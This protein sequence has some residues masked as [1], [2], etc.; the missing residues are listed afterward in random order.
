MFFIENFDF[1]AIGDITTDAFIRLKDASVHCQVN[2]ESCEICLKFADKVPFEFSEVVKAV[3]NAANAAVAASRLDLNTAI[4]TNVGDDENGRDCYKVLKSNGVSTK[5][6]KTQAGKPTNYHYVL[7]YEAERTILVN[8]VNYDYSLPA[9]AKRLHTNGWVYLTSLGNGTEKYHEEI[10]DWVLSQPQIKLAF[11]PGTFQMKLG[12]DKLK[13]IYARTD[14]F[15]CN[16]E[17]AERILGLGLS[18]IKVLLEGIRQL[19]PKTILITDGP[20]GAYLYDDA[21]YFMP[22]YPDP[23]PPYER[24]GC[25]D[26]FAAT[27]VSALALGKST[28]EALMWAPVNSMSVVQYV[29]AQKGLLNR[30]SL[31]AWL[32]KK[33][34]DYRPRKI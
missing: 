30:E 12:I 11:Q 1:I 15:I 28:E 8:H 25:G 32:A 23:K 7:W 31:E 14:V 19:G 33:P 4:I 9:Q 20:K 2:N 22:I 17:E 27:F 10:A 26:A 6:M 3:G 5:L 16:K 29:G 21:M 34:T 13:K 24:T 18:D